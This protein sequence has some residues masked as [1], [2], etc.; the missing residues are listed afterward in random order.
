MSNVTIAEAREILESSS[1]FILGEKSLSDAQVER[2]IELAAEEAAEWAEETDLPDPETMHLDWFLDDLEDSG[3]TWVNMQR[4]AF[5][6]VRRASARR[7]E[8]V[9]KA[10]KW[11]FG[12]LFDATIYEPGRLIISVADEDAEGDEIPDFIAAALPEWA[13]AEWTGNGDSSGD[14]ENTWDLQITW[15]AM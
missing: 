15:S 11:A 7:G 5:L 9:V 6:L 13:S 8:E 14:G 4:L 2:A 3:I 1:E 12:P 10:L